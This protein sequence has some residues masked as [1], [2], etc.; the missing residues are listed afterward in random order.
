MVGA[1]AGD[2]LARPMQN[3]HVLNAV[4]DNFFLG[5]TVHLC[6]IVM[7]RNEYGFNNFYLSRT[8]SIT[9]QHKRFLDL[10]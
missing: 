7:L 4:F 5:C 2:A 3:T 9:P 10:M 1:L 6:V 8:R